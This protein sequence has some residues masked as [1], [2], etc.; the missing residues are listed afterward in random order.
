[1]PVSL[2]TCDLIKGDL[3]SNSIFLRSTSHGLLPF[4]IFFRVDLPACMLELIFLDGLTVGELT[5]DDVGN[6]V[7]VFIGVSI[8]LLYVFTGVLVVTGV[9]RGVNIFFF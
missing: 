6:L 1:M 8:G 2:S 4:F 3:G 9:V 7:F 5:L